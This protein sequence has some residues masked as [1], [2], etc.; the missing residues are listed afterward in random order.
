MTMNLNIT[1]FWL[2]ANLN[3]QCRSFSSALDKDP[4][5]D[6]LKFSNEKRQEAGVRHVCISTENSEQVG[7]MGV[8]SIIDGKTPDGQEYTWR[9]RR[10]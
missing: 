9:K 4:L 6:A 5:G 3:P 8:D 2:D 10:R 1:V 7:Q